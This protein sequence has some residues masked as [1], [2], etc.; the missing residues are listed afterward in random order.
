MCRRT[1]HPT[2]SPTP[3]TKPY[4]S[5][6]K[7]PENVCPLSHQPLTQAIMQFRSLIAAFATALLAS[8]AIAAPVVIEIEALDD[9]VAS[10][11]EHSVHNVTKPVEDV[12]YCGWRPCLAY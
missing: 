4:S 3:T 12:S 1:H 6:N 7:A 9:V 2:L 8:S 5:P 11:L 10:E